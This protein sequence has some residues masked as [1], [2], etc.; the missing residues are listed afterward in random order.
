[1]DRKLSLT[2]TCIN[3]AGVLGFAVC[4]L[5]GPLSMCYITSIFIAWGLVIMN[6]GFYHYGRSDARVAAMCALVFGGMYAI[7]N[8][9]VYFTQLT[10][11]AND[12]LNDQAANILIFNRYG[13]IFD[14]DML[15]YCL[16]AFSTF[17]AGLTINVKDRFDKWLKVLLLIHGIFAGTCFIMPM[18]GLFSADMEGASWIGTLIL[19]IWCVYFIPI[20]VL[21]F[22]HF[23]LSESAQ[24]CNLSDKVSNV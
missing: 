5:T 2:G 13:L 23:Y 18:L 14:L 20:G 1:M 7:C 9:I 16:M 24:P 4:M 6:C 22:R 10:T 19:E 17:F 11:V 3:L 12:V 21:A 15:G 8:S